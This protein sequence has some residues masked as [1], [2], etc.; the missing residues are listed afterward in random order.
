ML[1]KNN[2]LSTLY[3][4]FQRFVNYTLTRNEAK[5]DSLHELPGSKARYLV[6]KKSASRS[7]TGR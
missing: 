1:P 5:P 4:L 6:P 2:H 3:R 7:L